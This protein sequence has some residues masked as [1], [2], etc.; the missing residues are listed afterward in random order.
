MKHIR[1]ALIGCMALILICAFVPG[2]PARAEG[3]T[4][5]AVSQS[6]MNVGDKLTVTVRPSESATINLQYNSNVLKLV[7]CSAQGYTS[8]GNVITYTGQTA[9][10]TFEA[11]GSGS[12]YLKATSEGQKVSGASTTVQVAG[13]TSQGQTPSESAQNAGTNAQ[14]TQS[15]SQTQG[16]FEMDGTS[17]VVSER[18]TAREIP[19]GFSKVEL[20]IQGSSYTELSNGKLTLI[21]LKPASNI[22]GSGAFYIY[23]E[24]EQSVMPMVLI[25][26]MEDY[27]IL[28]EPGEV[29]GKLAQADFS[30]GD[31][32]ISGYRIA[33]DADDF[34]YLY[35]MDETGTEQ[36]FEYDARDGSM[37][38]AN[39]ALLEQDDTQAVKQVQM[40]DGAKDGKKDISM[41]RLVIAILIFVLVVLAIVVINL[42]LSRRRKQEEFDFAD[43]EEDEDF[44][45]IEEEEDFA[46]SVSVIDETDA[47]EEEFYEND[48]PQMRAMFSETEDVQ[49]A[50][51]EEDR[52]EDVS[53]EKVLETEDEDKDE[54]EDEVAAR[55]ER[56]LD[57][58]NLSE[59]QENP[60]K[61]TK[62]K[63]KKD[64]SDEEIDFHDLEILDLNDL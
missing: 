43:E 50:D 52:Q 24:Q 9:E 49:S 1:K 29:P 4:V 6:S 60:K 25:G 35:G 42:I 45:E 5:I 31:Q 40:P 63:K 28:L 14:N 34:Y 38:R 3:T 37:Q 16:Q 61:E 55:L 2:L 54:D 19:A 62:E 59:E 8:Q 44:P 11:V 51:L 18:Y 36:W 53:L 26:S 56:E 10:M 20:T 21:Y 7:G 30:V 57:Q 64:L 15:P 47:G 41:L 27:V 12:S 33:E 48:T 22:S 58:L 13:S 23:N 46:K 32:Q 39:T 17:Y